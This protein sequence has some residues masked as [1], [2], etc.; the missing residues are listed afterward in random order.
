MIKLGPTASAYFP[1]S[2]KKKS[3][4]LIHHLSLTI[5]L[6]VVGTIGIKLGPHIYLEIRINEIGLMK[7]VSRSD[8]IDIGTFANE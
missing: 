7:F 1:L 4:A 8:V 5:P 2:S 6:G 3:Q